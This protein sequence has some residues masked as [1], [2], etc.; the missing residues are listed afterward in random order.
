[1]ATVKTYRHPNGHWQKLAVADLLKDGVGALLSLTER[2][3][4]VYSDP[5]WSP[6]N[7]KWW[8][9]HAGEFQPDSY[10]HFLDA[11]CAAVSGL[12]PKHVVVEQSVNPAHK[13]L[14]VNAVRRC[15]EWSAPLFQQEW[16]ALYGSPRRPNVVLHFGPQPIPTDP[17][18]MHGD[19]MTRCVFSGLAQIGAVQPG[20]II[21]DPCTGFGMTSRMAHE[22]GCNFA[23]TELAAKRMDRTAAWLLRHGYTEIL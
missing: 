8:R 7:E 17:S 12:R 6:G 16:I 9:N 14:F 22:F 2:A 20:M 10:D 23:G 5:P 19:A 13:A 11:W 3:D 18:G 21:A 4:I 1:M 15:Q